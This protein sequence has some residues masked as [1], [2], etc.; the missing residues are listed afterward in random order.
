MNHFNTKLII[1]NNFKAIWFCLFVLIVF[2]IYGAAMLDGFQ[3]YPLYYIA[4]KS[5]KWIEYKNMSNKLAL[6]IAAPSVLWTLICIPLIWLR[7]PAVPKITVWLS[8]ILIWASE[9]ITTKMAWPIHRQLAVS[10]SD[11]LV[12]K[13][14]FIDR[15]YRKVPQTINLLL[16]LYLLFCVTRRSLHAKLSS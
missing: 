5:D 3:A 14:L 7:P 15:W 13:L 16:V 6:P 2:Y 4:G 8:I 11:A 1:M 10:Y 9:I 12:D